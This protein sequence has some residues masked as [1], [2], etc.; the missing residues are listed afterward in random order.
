MR[1]KT[2]TEV[3]VA[4]NVRLKMKADGDKSTGGIGDWQI[5]NK[6]RSLKSIETD[7]RDSYFRIKHTHIQTNIL[8]LWL[9]RPLPLEKRTN[10]PIIKSYTN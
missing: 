6:F 4:E 9:L 10:E 3:F 2:E 5:E 8:H 1:T 7:T